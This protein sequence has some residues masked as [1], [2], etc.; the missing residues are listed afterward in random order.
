M[1]SLIRQTW[2]GPSCL[3]RGQRLYLPDYNIIIYTLKNVL[4][5]SANSADPVGLHCLQKYV[6]IYVGVTSIKRDIR[7]GLKKSVCN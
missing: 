1:D 7:L 6:Y 2:T 3:L 5:A 4:V